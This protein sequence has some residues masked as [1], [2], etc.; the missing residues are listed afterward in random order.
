M[1]GH[2][3]PETD[4]E[5]MVCFGDIDA[6]NYVEYQTAGEDTWLPSGFCEDCLSYLLSSQWNQ[7]VERLRTTNCKAEQRRLITAGPPVYISDKNALPCPEGSHVSALWFSGDGEER[8]SV[9]EGALQGEERERFWEEQRQFVE[10]DGDEE[11][12]NNDTTD[13]S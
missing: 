10:A 6:T 2:S 7:Y 5:C 3:Q 11:E 4:K 1:S 12:D 9:L 8:S 13:E